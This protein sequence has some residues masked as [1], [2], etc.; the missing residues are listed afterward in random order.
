MADTSVSMDDP[1]NAK[2]ATSK[3]KKCPFCQQSFTSSS[4]GRHLDLYI[5]EKNP[6]PADGIHHVEEIRKLRGQITRRQPRNSSGRAH[7]SHGREDSIT[8]V[9]PAASASGRRSPES[10]VTIQYSRPGLR[11]ANGSADGALTM[12]SPHTEKYAPAETSSMDDRAQSIFEK[13]HWRATGVINDIPSFR[14]E[15]SQEIMRGA[16]GS[17]KAGKNAQTSRPADK[18]SIAKANFE[19]RQRLSDAQ[20]EAKAAKLALREVLG[21]LKAAK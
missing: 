8:S 16:Y 1:T 17:V 15:S 2:T 14:E 6:K 3:D 10:A 18:Q 9:T 21:A 5:K 20:D 13:T 12:A 7:S 11:S 19:H 4:L